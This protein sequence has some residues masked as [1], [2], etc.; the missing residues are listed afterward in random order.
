MLDDNTDCDKP[1][2]IPHKRREMRHAPLDMADPEP[3]LS[4]RQAAED[5]AH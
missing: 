5:T 3:D 2:H 4:A 1:A